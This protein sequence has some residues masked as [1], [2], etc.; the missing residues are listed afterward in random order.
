MGS[1]ARV[2]L[3]R[4]PVVAS[5]K[6]HADWTRGACHRYTHQPAGLLCHA[7]TCLASPPSF[8]YPPSSDDLSLDRVDVNVVISRTVAVT[9]TGKGEHSWETVSVRDHDTRSLSTCFSVFQTNGYEVSL[10]CFPANS[11]LRSTTPVPEHTTL[12]NL[13]SIAATRTK[14]TGDKARL[15]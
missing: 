6:K 14:R 15:T 8:F 7:V 5:A 12:Q 2:P 4:R 1:P 13:S 11:P 10:Q 3:H 9:M